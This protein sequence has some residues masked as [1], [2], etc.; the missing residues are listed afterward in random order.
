MSLS[1][2]STHDSQKNA[3]PRKWGSCLWE[4]LHTMAKNY[5][6]NPDPQHKA[7]ARQF[8][9]SLRHLLPCITCRQNYAIHLAKRQPNVDSSHKLQEWILWL[10]NE[11][12]AKVNGA[13]PWTMEQIESRY[14]LVDETE[15]E[16]EN[17]TE[18]HNDINNHNNHNNNNH[19][20][21]PSFSPSL[22]KLLKPLTDIQVTLNQS[23]GNIQI[24]K[25]TIPH[26][27][28]NITTTI[29]KSPPPI[30][31][32]PNNPIRSR[33]LS[34][35][36][37]NNRFGLKNSAIGLV[38]QRHNSVNRQFR[39]PSR[40]KP[41]SNLERSIQTRNAP[42][43]IQLKLNAPLTSQHTTTAATSTR[44]CGSNNQGL[45]QQKPGGCGCKGK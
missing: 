35:T 6:D 28:K 30:R 26:I 18:L 2:S 11:V 10:H 14:N 45:K 8:I 17:H 37:I 33:R 24:A 19:P 39:Q 1:S 4:F 44:G 15:S 31:D 36:K 25:E 29:S 22:Q 21:Y 41:V 42:P 40:N 27:N 13:E 20:N 9:F 7:S 34:T 32:I 3:D 38:N 12:N 5:P 16:S 43:P 23:N